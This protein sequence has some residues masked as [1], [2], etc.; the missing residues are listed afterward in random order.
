[1]GV[2]VR[3]GERTSMLGSL[4]RRAVSPGDRRPPCP[5][6]PQ[7]PQGTQGTRNSRDRDSGVVHDRDRTVAGGLTG[8]RA[9]PRPLWHRTDACGVYQGAPGSR[10][11]VGGMTVAQ[12]VCRRVSRTW[13]WVLV[14]VLPAVAAL[15][16]LATARATGQLSAGE[17]TSGGMLVL[18]TSPAGV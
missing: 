4:K 6:G 12:P 16:V 13:V 8:G 7:G 18:V 9:D 15:L 14:A 10:G 3:I 11:G 17:A 5:Q 2:E 1:M